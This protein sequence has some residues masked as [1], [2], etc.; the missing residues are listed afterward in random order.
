MEN[1]SETK[2]EE[3]DDTPQKYK[4]RG[5]VS[6]WSRYEERPLFLDEVEDGSDYLIGEDF[7]DVL[8][9]QSKIVMLSFR[10]NL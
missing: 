5:I 9:N 2:P 1:K 3:L 4:R 8:H 6:N 7:A 10:A